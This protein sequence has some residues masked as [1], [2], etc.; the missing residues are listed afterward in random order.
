MSWKRKSAIPRHSSGDKSK[1]IHVLRPK[2]SPKWIT[3]E[4]DEYQNGYPVGHL[5][6]EVL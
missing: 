4:M 6:D 1:T 3:T 2:S 5:D